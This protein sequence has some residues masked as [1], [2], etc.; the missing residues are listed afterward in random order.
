MYDDQ[1]LS[2]LLLDTKAECRYK[3]TWEAI[4]I[5]TTK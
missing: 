2:S 3:W 1:M 5:Y 4:Q